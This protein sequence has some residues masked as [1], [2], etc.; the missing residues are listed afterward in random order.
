MTP[1]PERKL[2]TAEQADRTLP[3]VRRIVKDIV[4]LYPE[5]RDRVESYAVY[6][7]RA[8]AEHP[9]P[10]ADE[11][12]ADVQRLA[13]DIDGCLR[14]LAALGV[15]YKQPL[16]AGLVDFPGMMDGRSVFFC[17]RYD[18]PAVAHW[19]DREAGFAGR[20]PLAPARAEAN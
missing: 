8:S 2:F 15:E 17:W 20:R 11:A 13:K 4:T 6:A 3:L 10:R 18:E 16:D 19:H 9:D 12:A 7:A 5:W 14:E 1:R